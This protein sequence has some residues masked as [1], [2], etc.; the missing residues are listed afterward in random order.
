MKGDIYDDYKMM[1]M[2]MIIFVPHSL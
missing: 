1:N 2:R